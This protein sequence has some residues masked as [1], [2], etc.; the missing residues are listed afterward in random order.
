MTKPRKKYR[1]KGV[2]LHALT[3]ATMGVRFLSAAD[4]EVRVKFV[5]DAL[6]LIRSGNGS[7]DAWQAIFDALNMIEQFGQVP[8]VIQGNLRDW[9][10]AQQQTIVTILDRQKEG[11]RAL[12]ASELDDLMALLEMW[13]SILQNVTHRQYFEAEDATHKRLA[14][15]LRSGTKGVRVVKVVDLEAA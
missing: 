10:E 9:V 5:R 7:K 2:N 11:K 1:P 6:D 8:G 15:I 3:V 4:I 12:Y 13:E 14:A